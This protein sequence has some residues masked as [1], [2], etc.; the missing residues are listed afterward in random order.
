[1]WGMGMYPDIAAMTA[2][3]TPAAAESGS[4]NSQPKGDQHLRS[5]REV[6][7]YAI[8][9]RD[10]DLGHVGDFLVD[11]ASWAIRSMVVDTR[12]WL[13]GKH[14]LVPTDS[15]TEVSWEQASVMV[16]LTRE[17][18]RQEPEYDPSRLN[19]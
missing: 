6:G 17:A 15:I 2:A 3:A 9:A 18:I 5:A 14:V 19:R 7:H 16:D 4:A 12:N 11:D 8:H 10:G 13:P 1:M